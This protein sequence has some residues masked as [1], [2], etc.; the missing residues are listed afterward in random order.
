VKDAEMHADDDKKKR[1]LVDARNSA[2][3]LIYSTEKSLKEMGDKIDA[4][5]RAI[6]KPPSNR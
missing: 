2:D 5:P 3:A 4:R 6:S 1:E